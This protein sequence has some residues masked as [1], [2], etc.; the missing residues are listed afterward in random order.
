MLTSLVDVLVSIKRASVGRIDLLETF[1]SRRI[2]PVQERARPMWMYEGLGDSTRV[3]PQALTG[4]EIEDMVK[5]IT[6]V[7]DDTQGGR[8]VAPYDRDPLPPEVSLHSSVFIVLKKDLCIYSDF[9]TV[10]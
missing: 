4:M 6:S 10:F 5:L 2:Q 8:K 1:L 3:H 9:S 7:R